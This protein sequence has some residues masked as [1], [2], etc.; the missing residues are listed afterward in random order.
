MELGFLQKSLIF[1]NG[2]SNGQRSKQPGIRQYVQI[3][4]SVVIKMT[5]LWFTFVSSAYYYVFFNLDIL[6]EH[7]CKNLTWDLKSETVSPP[8]HLYDG[9]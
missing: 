9:D 6:R 3:R 7:R 4:I 2:M 1:H 5:P 8:L